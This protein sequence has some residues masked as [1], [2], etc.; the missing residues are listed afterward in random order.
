MKFLFKFKFECPICGTYSVD[1]DTFDSVL[2]D[3]LRKRVESVIKDVIW[4]NDKAL[5]AKFEKNC[6][7]CQKS[8]KSAIKIIVRKFIS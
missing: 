8:G 6:P 2:T 7:R 5:V 4:Q 1:R 3:N